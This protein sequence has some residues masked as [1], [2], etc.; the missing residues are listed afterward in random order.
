MFAAAV[1]DHPNYPKTGSA[2]VLEVSSIKEVFYA[3]SDLERDEWI[4][5][6]MKYSKQLS[7]DNAYE[8]ARSDETK[9]GAGSESANFR[10]SSASV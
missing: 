6:V 7:I 3:P 1:D 9:L 4:D 5:T 10:F 2:F 8:I